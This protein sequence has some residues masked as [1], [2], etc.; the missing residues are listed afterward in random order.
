MASEFMFLT[1][2]TGRIVFL[3]LVFCLHNS[4]PVRAAWHIAQADPGME[5]IQLFQKGYC[6]LLSQVYSKAF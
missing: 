3:V 2:A 1:G 4:Y 6:W 5:I